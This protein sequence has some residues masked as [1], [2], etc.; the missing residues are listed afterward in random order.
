LKGINLHCYSSLPLPP[1]TN[2]EKS[3]KTVIN[4]LPP[5]TPA[6]VIPNGPEELGVPVTNVRQMTA[7]RAANGPKELGFPVTNV[8]QMTTA[9]RAANGQTSLT[10]LPVPPY[11]IQKQRSQDIKKLN[12]LNETVI[13]VNLHRATRVTR[14]LAMC[15]PTVNTHFNVCGE[16]V[17]NCVENSS[18]NFRI[19]VQLVQP[20]LKSRRES[21]CGAIA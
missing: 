13:K 11:F 4:P 14:T 3:I 18:E 20:H 9:T 12:G 16:A 8:R 5:N 6:E 1:P 15:G 7:T 19:R 10:P 21:L 2:F 17:V